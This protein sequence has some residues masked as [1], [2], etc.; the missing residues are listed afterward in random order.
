MSTDDSASR[1]GIRYEPDEIPPAPLSFGFGLQLTVLTIAMPI[2][3][4]TIVMGISGTSEA[5]MTWA[6]FAAVAVCGGATALQAVRYGR[7]GCGHTLAMTSSPA[8][9]WLCVEA[10]EKGGPAMLATLVVIASLFQFV[11]AWRIA[12]LRRILTPTVTGTLL[13][14]VPVTVMPVVFSMMTRVPEGSSAQFALYSAAV[15][16]LVIVGIALKGTPGLRLWAPVIGVVAGSLVAGWFGLYD[17]DRVAEASWVGMPNVEWPGLDLE[18]GPA[19]W[20]LLPAFILL[21]LVV[22]LRSISGAVAVQSVSWRR[23]R[24]V[25]FRDVQGATAVDG[26]SNLLCGLAGTVPSSSQPVTASLTEL[27]GVAARSVGIVAGVMFI[28]LAFLP[29]AVAVV[30]AIP[31]PVVGG[32]FAVLLAMLFLVGVK[33]LLQEGLDYRK[34]LIAG[35]AFWTGVGFENGVI[36]PEIVAG[37]GDDILGNGLTSGGLAAILMTLF[38]ESIGPRR[39]RMEAEFDPSALSKV[40]SFLGSFA[41]RSGWNREMAARLD[42]VGEEALLSLLGSDGGGTEP[43][44]RRRLQLV[45]SRGDGGAVLE[46][47]V[48]PQGENIQ[49]RLAMLQDQRDE[50]HIE[51]EVSLRLLRHLSSSVRHKQF[52]DV[53]VV[54]VHVKP[55]ATS[56]KA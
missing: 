49:D 42:A 14:L 43:D 41:D 12:L 11:L 40:R 8:F 44:R 21:T 26:I 36:F 7:I 35:V 10:I 37:F 50:S 2:L 20:S 52:H 51:H 19:F 18:F 3:V 24:T 54:T 13:M 4:P 32:Y 33:V 53:D 56:G 38:V 29:K 30:L 1:S 31:G 34:G 27:T 17:L 28:V 6:V 23:A 22:T 9:V 15:T 55:P 45:A 39:R 25:N 48:A 47:T 5:H 46:F 16:V